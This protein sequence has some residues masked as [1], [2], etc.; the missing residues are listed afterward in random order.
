MGLRW[1]SRYSDV[2]WAG[3]SGFEPL[4]GRGF[5]YL[6]RSD[7]RLTQPPVHWAPDPFPGS[8]SDWAWCW[9]PTLSGTEFEKK[10]Q[11]YSPPLPRL[12]LRGLLW[13]KLNR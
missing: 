3:G 9:P 1:R 7:P 8:K 6:S 2:L 13:G 4:W 12:D 11:T 10:N 5:P